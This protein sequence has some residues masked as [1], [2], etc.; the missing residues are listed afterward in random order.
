MENQSFLSKYGFTVGLLSIMIVAILWVFNA[1]Q[2]TIPGC[3]RQV[4]MNTFR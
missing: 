1:G 4:K 3:E 2:A